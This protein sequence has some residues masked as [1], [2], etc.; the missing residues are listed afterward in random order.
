MGLI[1][2]RRA[3][4]AGLCGGLLAGAMIAAASTSTQA[5]P[6]GCDRACLYQ[7]LDQYL[8][9]VVRHDPSNAPLAKGF[10]E[11]ENAVD[12]QPGDGIW[13]NAVG[14]G[15]VQRR[16]FDPVSG[17]AAYFGLV[18]EPGAGPALVGVRIKVVHRKITEAEWFIAR[19]GMAL[20]SPTGLVAKPPRSD[21]PLPA[22]D[23]LP[24]E[25]LLK[26]ASSY[27]EG[28]TAHDGG[29]VIAKD[30]CN[31][32]EN[33]TQTTGLPPRPR[34]AVAPVPG[35]P[36]TSV[37]PPVG[38]GVSNCHS[39]FERLTK[40]VEAVVERRFPVVDTQ[41]GVVMG[42]GIFHPAT[43]MKSRDGSPFPHLMLSEFFAVDQGKI[44]TVYAAMTYLPQ[45]APEKTSW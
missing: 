10:R 11:T 14:L 44:D 9:A 31:R 28:L 22:A 23:Q 16:Y 1:L 12:T 35:A 26:V 42:I 21:T 37:A 8:G 4:R 36:V 24:R 40:A 18:G 29:M 27:F 32:F 15:E 34:P 2:G 5:A 39:A 30:S 13:K 7:A 6:N 33:G 19:K 25:Q 43:D 3:R 17:Q 45:S 20:Y 41:A 38:A